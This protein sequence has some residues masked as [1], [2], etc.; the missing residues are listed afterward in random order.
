MCER[1]KVVMDRGEIATR[2]YGRLWHTRCAAAYAK[3]R[4]S[5]RLKTKILTGR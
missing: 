4:N 1:C 3:D 5:E 2:V